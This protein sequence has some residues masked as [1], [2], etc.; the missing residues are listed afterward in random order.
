MKSIDIFDL[1]NISNPR[2]IDIRD[3]YKYGLG[4]IPGS[5]NVPYL[6]LVT[7]P[8]NYLNKKEIYYLLCDSGN[9]SLRCSLEL[10]GMGY[11]VI[12]I[13]GGYNSYLKYKRGS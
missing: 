13:D 10:S 7:N 9:T 11:N 1:M 2:I 5:I 8:G 6:F 3:N 4:T 12:N